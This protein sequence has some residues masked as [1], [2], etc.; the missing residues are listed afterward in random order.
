MPFFS[1]SR[2]LFPFSASHPSA[3]MALES[4]SSLPAS[5]LT[6]TRVEDR[7]AA[8]FRGGIAL[9]DRRRVSSGV[10]V[11][12]EEAICS[13]CLFATA[14][15][16]RRALGLLQLLLL[17]FGTVAAAAARGRAAAASIR[18]RESEKEREKEKGRKEKYENFAT[19]P[20]TQLPQRKK[21]T[22]KF[23]KL[24]TEK[25]QCTK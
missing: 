21:T 4:M 22:K 12:E 13:C 7:A 19:T 5:C 20:S 23:G 17:L 14:G 11:D 9:G 3:G 2:S 18:E 6:R 8:L 1:L 25:N 10:D 24:S 15:L 16:S